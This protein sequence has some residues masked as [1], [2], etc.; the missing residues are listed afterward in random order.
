MGSIYSQNLLRWKR[1]KF[2]G[3]S[4]R[5]SSDLCATNHQKYATF[6]ASALH[7]EVRCFPAVLYS[8][9]PVL[10]D[11]PLLGT[12]NTEIKSPFGNI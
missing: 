1:F 2:L 3:H 9:K 8:L 5:I 12:C 11:A 10:E 7:L 4:G 6:K